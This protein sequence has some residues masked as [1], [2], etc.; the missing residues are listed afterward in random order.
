MYTNSLLSAYV[1]ASPSCFSN[2]TQRLP[3]NSLNDRVAL[4]DR[5]S[6]SI[7]QPS[8]PKWQHQ[9][10]PNPLAISVQMQTSVQAENGEFGEEY[11]R[12]FASVRQNICARCISLT[13]LASIDR[14]RLTRVSDL[15]ASVTNQRIP[16]H[17]L[18]QTC[19][20][21]NF[22]SPAPVASIAGWSMVDRQHIP[23]IFKCQSFAV[24]H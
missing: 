2:H 20:S 6:R 16:P 12:Y 4:R 15:R 11:K 21:L 13:S 1:I 9:Q 24:L 7:S 19:I 10:T 23:Y 8:P 3:P 22:R 18:Q 14:P 17:A 5:M